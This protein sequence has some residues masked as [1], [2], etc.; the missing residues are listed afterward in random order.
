MESAFVDS[1]RSSNTNSIH[2]CLYTTGAIEGFDF[3][4]STFGSENRP[5]NRGNVCMLLQMLGRYTTGPNGRSSDQLRERWSDQWNWLGDRRWTSVMRSL[6]K[7][8]PLH[9]GW[10]DRHPAI[11]QRSSTSNPRQ[12]TV[13][14][15]AHGGPTSVLPTDGTQ[16]EKQNGQWLDP[17]TFWYSPVACHP[18]VNQRWRFGA[19]PDPTAG[20]PL[21]NH[22]SP[23]GG[24]TKQS[25]P[26]LEICRNI[27][28]TVPTVEPGSFQRSCDPTVKPPGK[29]ITLRT[30]DCRIGLLR[31]RS[32]PAGCRLSATS[33]A[34][35]KAATGWTPH[36]T[37]RGLLRHLHHFSAQSITFLTPSQL[38]LPIKAPILTLYHDTANSPAI[39]MP[40][41]SHNK[42]LCTCSKCVSHTFFDPNTNTNCH[43]KYLARRTIQQHQLQDCNTSAM[44]KFK[45]NDSTVTESSV[46]SSSS[47]NYSVFEGPD[48]MEKSF[49]MNETRNA[50]DYCTNIPF[51]D[52]D[53]CGQELFKYR[54]SYC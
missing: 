38:V 5:S 12:S 32:L 1:E 17:S 7:R 36:A 2:L 28:A 52:K 21:V 34:S 14:N 6:P 53:S 15:I 24:P 26:P 46:V 16:R 45:I 48:T 30:I 9:N 13:G 11:T 54:R 35:S 20:R 19:Y 41:S 22:R 4:P 42:Y 8:A 47:S 40:P 31:L 33:A 3:V 10:T 29:S 27:V 39:Q 51:P 44:E 50:P 49:L 18:A 23:D 25:G 43:G 37:P